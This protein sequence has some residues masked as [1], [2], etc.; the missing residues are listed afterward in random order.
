M[1]GHRVCDALRVPVPL[2]SADQ[3]FDLQRPLMPRVLVTAALGNVGSEV[4]RECAERG[5]MVRAAGRAE[6]EL[7]AR[8]PALE[9]VRFDFLD[10]GTWAGA[11]AG[12]DAVFLL[13][14]PPLGDMDA[15]L[16]P[17]VDAAYAAGA[18][19][20]VFL[21]V[22]G[23]DRM[24]WVPHRKVELHLASTGK[25]WTVLRPGFFAQNLKD[26]Y[27]RDIVEDGHLYVPAADGRVAFLDVRDAAEIAALIFLEQNAYRQKALTLT[28]PEA[29]TF[30][31]VAELLSGTLGKT[32][33]YDPASILGYI[34]HL[35]NK[36]NQSW[37]QVMVQTILH[38][39]LRR[40]DAEAVEG[41]VEQLLGRPPRSLADYIARDAEVWRS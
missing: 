3:T 16:N 12:C 39:G 1:S 36:R 11:L 14:P 33:H 4:V 19:H 40:G 21:S 2:A 24:K 22:A 8:F 25:A 20:I 41:T 26:A 31:R 34:W 28:G 29:I 9:S 35:R 38:V 30:A 6:A 32:I 7:K 5:L 37:M 23:A 15:T 13:R 17:F 27:R 10:R 18:R